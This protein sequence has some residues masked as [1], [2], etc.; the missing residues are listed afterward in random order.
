MNSSYSVDI[1]LHKTSTL[2]LLDLKKFTRHFAEVHREFMNVHLTIILDEFNGFHVESFSALLVLDM[3]LV[4]DLV[5]K[6]F[7]YILHSSL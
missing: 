4:E 5:G 3:V 1:S 6:L 7:P 2:T